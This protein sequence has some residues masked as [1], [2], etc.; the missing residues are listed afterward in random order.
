M[1]WQLYTLQEQPH[2]RTLMKSLKRKKMM[3]SHVA[4][5]SSK[6]CYFMFFQVWTP[7][8]TGFANCVNTKLPMKDAGSTGLRRTMPSSPGDALPITANL[9]RIKLMSG[10]RRGSKYAWLSLLEKIANIQKKKN[11]QPRMAAISI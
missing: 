5:S 6:T 7:K 10:M 11:R 3:R 4:I 9:Y 8:A 2:V 1:P